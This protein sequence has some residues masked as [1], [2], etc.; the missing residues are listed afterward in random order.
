MVYTGRFA[1]SPTGPLHFGSLLAAV[2][3]YLDARAHNGLWLL[4]IEDLDPPR[5]AEGAT[6]SIFRTLEQF[7][8]HWDGE[9]IRQS[10]RLAIYNDILSQ[11]SNSGAAYRC[12]CS[13]QQIQKRSSNPLYDR[14]CRSHPPMT[15]ARCAMR[16]RCDQDY[17]FDD[18]IQGHQQ[19]SN[20]TEDFVIFRRDGFFAY[21]LAVTIDDAAQQISHI[22]RGSDLLDSTPKQIH[23]QQKLG[24]RQPV[25]AHIPVA[26]NRQGQKLSKQTL[27]PALD[28]R[29]ALQLTIR[30]LDF[31]GQQP[32]AEL[33]DG[34]IE[35]CLCWATTHWDITAIPK[36]TGI[37]LEDN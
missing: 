17:P 5:E 1:P 15:G 31:L 12:S 14:H 25:Y 36:Q 32:V 26:T 4:R 22:V 11:L 24:Y 8:L 9:V 30:A 23:L 33:A 21:Q 29:Q 27:A 37:I 16:I 2:A 6:D 35:E 3:S 10:D 34:T 28:E 13:R 19:F 18:L 7:G 20:L